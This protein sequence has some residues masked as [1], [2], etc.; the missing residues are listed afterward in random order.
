MLPRQRLLAELRIGHCRWCFIAMSLAACLVGC[1][2]KQYDAVDRALAEKVRAP[3]QLADVE[4]ELGPAHEPTRAQVAC[5]Q[6][7]VVK[8]PDQM[9][10]NAEADKTLAWGNDRGFLVVK[11]NPE[12]NIWVTSYQFGGPRPAGMKPPPIPP[13]PVHLGPPPNIPSQ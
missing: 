7:R 2:E 11:V 8:M 4:R 6:E 12:G 9:R 13:A 5:M 3:A 10:K 1:Q